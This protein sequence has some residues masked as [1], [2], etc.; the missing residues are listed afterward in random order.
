MA[1]FTYYGPEMRIITR[2]FKNTN[3]GMAFKTNNTINI[4]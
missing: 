2:S 3:V 1:T 4:T